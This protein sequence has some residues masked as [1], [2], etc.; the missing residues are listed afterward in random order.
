MACNVFSIFRKVR[1]EAQAHESIPNRAETDGKER[2]GRTEV[3]VS[4]EYVV[5]VQGCAIADFYFFEELSL[6]L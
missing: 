4:R 5:A 2:A 6:A 3:S 1:L